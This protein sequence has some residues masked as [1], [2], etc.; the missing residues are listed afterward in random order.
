MEVIKILIWLSIVL[1][2]YSYIG[3]ALLIWLYLRVK[4]QFNRDITKNDPGFEPPVSLVVAA[5]NEEDVIKN[6]IEN[7]LALDYPRDKLKIVFVADGSTDNTPA[8]IKNY[9]RI[10]LLYKSERLGKVAAINRAME[11]ISTEFVIFCD[12]NT[13]LN[14]NCIKEIVKHYSDEKIGAVAGEKKVIA[15]AGQNKPAKDGEGLYWKYESKLKKIDS[16]FYTVVGAAGE[17]FSIRTKLFD[18]LDTNIL[19]DDFIIS[20]N[21]CKK[22]Y[23]VVYE[24]KAYAMEAPS[25]T[26]KDEQTRKIRISAGGFQSI[27]ML[28]DLLNIFKYG[29]LSYIYISHRVFR[30]VLCPVLLPVIF[31]CN[32]LL[33]R[34]APGSPVYQY[35]LTGQVIFYCMALSGWLLSLKNIKANL[36]YIPF[37]FVF[38]NFALYIGFFR[39]LNKRQTVLWDKARRK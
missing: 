2:F 7:C 20:M 38:M 28:K 33:V 10:E 23:R 19:L 18:P 31:F 25:L 32:L 5:F 12:A 26:L 13:F 22:G 1:V 21:I 24:P 9:P 27:L 16:D 36:L 37:Y 15:A 6:K 8:I 30:W 3:Y 39:F 34:Y 11:G 29:K 35:L 14:E 4:K 17:L